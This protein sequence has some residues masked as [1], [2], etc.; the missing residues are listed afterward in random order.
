MTAV[1]AVVF[2]LV[3]T[4]AI[5]FQLALA[6]GAPWGEYAMGGRFAGRLPPAMRIAAVGQAIVL[7]V[8]G[9]IVLADAGLVVPSIAS[10]LPSAI[11]LAVGFS[12][13][14]LALNAASRSPRERRVWVPVAAAMLVSSL[15]VAIT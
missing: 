8:L 7:A 1:A 9:T 5:A 15:V 4:I 13:L 2:G 12:A 6:A 11:W 10:G 3:T 14:S